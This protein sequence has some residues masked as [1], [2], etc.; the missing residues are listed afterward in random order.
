MTRNLWR[1]IR[2][3]PSFK[4]RFWARIFYLILNRNDLTHGIPHKIRIKKVIK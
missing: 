3:V 4:V 2:L 1:E